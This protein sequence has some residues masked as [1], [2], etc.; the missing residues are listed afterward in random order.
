MQHAGDER[1][2]RAA[3]L[4]G[5]GD[6]LGDL[7]HFDADPAACDAAALDDLLEHH[8]GGRH[9]DGEADPHR[10]AR[11]R[12]NRR[13][14]ADQ[15]AGRIDQRAAGVARVDRSVGLDEVLEGVDAK[16]GAAQGGDDAARDRLSD[17]ERIADG[18]HHVAD[19]QRVRRAEADRRKV[20]RVEAQHRE[21]GLGIDAD[22]F[23]EQLLAVGQCHLDLVG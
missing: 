23:R 16:A 21:I 7:L 5:F 12:E 17:A 3:E 15:V 9:G 10:A 20:L 8:L 11:A 13:V 19:A 2:P 18:E 4:E 22:H 1:A 14:D 6:R